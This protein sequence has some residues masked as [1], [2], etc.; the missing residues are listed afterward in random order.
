MGK[1]IDSGGLGD[2]LFSGSRKRLLELLFGN[3]DRSFYWNELQRLAGKGRG[4]P[5]RELDNLTAVGLVTTSKQ[6]N[7]MHYQANKHSPIFEEVRSIV[8]KTF[9]LAGPLKAALGSLGDA[10]SVAFVF[11]SVAKDTDTAGSDIDVFVLSDSIDY[12]KLIETL[13][14]CEDQLGRKIS[15]VLYSSSELKTKLAENASF[16]TRILAQP[17][18]PLIGDVDGISGTRE[19]GK[20]QPA[21]KGS[22]GSK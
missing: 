21:E 12:R 13:Q 4:G 7:Q 3:P 1:E 15:L 9:G 10:V 11:G 2:A 8:R 17:K 18:I 20:D 6:G 14:P 16:I 22:A 19:P 5:K